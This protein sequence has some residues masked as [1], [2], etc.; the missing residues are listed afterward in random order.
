VI[1][2]AK[3]IRKIKEKKAFTLMEV[4]IAASLFTVVGILGIS[5][6]V[7]VMR[8]QR[9]LAL[10]NAIYEDARFLME[11]IAREIRENAIDYEEYYRF[12]S[13]LGDTYG[14][15]FGCYAEQFYNPG[16][17]SDLG[18]ECGVGVL[19]DCKVIDKRSLDINTGENPY[20]QGS[21]DPLTASAVCDDVRAVTPCP[22][23]NQQD[24]LFLINSKGTLKTVFG[25]KSV[26]D[27]EHAAAMVRLF[28]VDDNTDGIAESWWDTTTIK[29]NCLP[30][31]DCDNLSATG[32]GGKSKLEDTLD[33]SASR[34]LYEGFIPVTPLRTNIASLTFYIAPME[35]PRKAFA[36]TD[37]VQGIQQQP[38]VTVVMT[39]KP[40]E[41]ELKDFA[42]DAPTVTVQTTVS[43]RV[44]NEV[45]SF[46]GKSA[47][48]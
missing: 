12:T 43:S 9:R 21:S 16:S 4:L 45:K 28:G 22:G 30:E 3:L 11:R 42:G 7:N 36:E 13:T 31:F 19:P 24:Q 10:E 33:Y 34:D 47:C 6:F 39:L 17:D 18:Y 48:P 8:I 41:S 1:T 25:L 35:D 27:S 29:Y 5:V 26:N 23:T 40:A 37:P 38:H 44:Q 20:A 32:A 2:P 14:S 15:N 46:T